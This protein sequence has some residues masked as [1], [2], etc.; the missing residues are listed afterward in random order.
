MAFYSLEPA[1]F[2]LAVSVGKGATSQATAFNWRDYL[3]LLNGFIGSIIGASAVLAGQYFTGRLQLRM[4][5]R[6]LAATE[7]LKQLEFDRIDSGVRRQVK[8]LVDQVGNFV[9]LSRKYGPVDWQKMSVFKERL[10][11]RIYLWEVSTALTD[12]QAEALYY[13]EASI[14]VNY[15]FALQEPWIGEDPHEHREQAKAIFNDSCGAL[16]KFWNVMGETQRSSK[17]R[18]LYEPHGEGDPLA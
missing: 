12:E 10:E 13:A 2:V 6:Q 8:A 15:R 11:S 17:F 1:V 16:A 18:E 4:Q 9:Y 7:N 14:D 3:P 5:T